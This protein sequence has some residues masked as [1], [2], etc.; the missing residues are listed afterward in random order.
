[1]GTIRTPAWHASPTPQAALRGGGLRPGAAMSSKP[2]EIAHAS[3]SPGEGEMSRRIKVFDWASTPLGPV[4]RWSQ[5]LKGAV[6]LCL[7]SGFPSAV[8]WGPELTLLY[9][10]AAR[11][12]HGTKHPG[13]LGQPGQKVW[14]EA[15][16]AVE[17]LLQRVLGAGETVTAQDLRLPAMR[18][19][20]TEEASFALSYS[21]LRD[22]EGAIA[23]LF[24]SAVETTTRVRAEAALRESE[25][26]MR[27]IVESARDYA[28]FTLDARGM[29]DAWLPGAITVFGWDVTEAVGQPGA[30]LFTPADIAAG[31]AERELA[32]ARAEGASPDVR[33]HV[34]KDGRRVF[35]E[36]KVVALRGP[37]GGVHG[38]LKIGQDVT[39]RRAADA[40][41]RDSEERFRTLAEGIPQLVWRA[42]ARGLWTWASPQWCDY[43]GQSEGASHGWGWLSA[44]HP[45]D[46]PAARAA[47]DAAGPQGRLEQEYRVRRARDGAWRWHT[48]RAV[49]VRGTPGPGWQGTQ[50]R[51][52]LGTS[53][54]IDDQIRA[55]EVLARAGEELEARVAERTAQ[56]LSAEESLRQAQKMEAVG[57]LTGG[58]AH[59]FNNMLQGVVGGLEM[60]QRR[61]DDGRH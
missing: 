14:E 36:G 33:W 47:W 4:E 56:L 44:V 38:Y 40:A 52:W 59:D 2:E 60:A 51:E 23:G 12:I 18:G 22:D 29:I 3:W 45:E 9:N 57:Q 34:R 39:E 7:S 43:T 61:I 35:I 49:P 8:Y 10:D 53:T 30:M 28:I 32:T 6:E 55:R 15:W 1:M 19:D 11:A 13:A 5:G 25:A 24:V 48:A 31:E 27:L 41:L 58:I 42:S 54:D 21:P 46:H 37:A 17:P 26:R 50:I 20:A 16:P